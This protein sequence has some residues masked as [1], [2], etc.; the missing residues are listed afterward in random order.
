MSVWRNRPRLHGNLWGCCTPLLPAC[1]CMCPRR[2]PPLHPTLLGAEPSHTSRGSPARQP[3]P[4]GGGSSARGCQCASPCLCVAS[5]VRWSSGGGQAGGCS[6][7]LLPGLLQLG[8]LLLGAGLG[9]AEQRGLPLRHREAAFPSPP[10]PG[11]CLSGSRRAV[12]PGHL[13]VAEQQPPFLCTCQLQGLARPQSPLAREGISVRYKAQ[14][15]GHAYSEVG[16]IV[17]SGVYSR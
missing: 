4:V 12:P 15:A 1:L 6:Q 10:P 16:P 7:L 2:R 11:R 8:G 9:W 13:A 17:I 14:Q 5:H 3:L